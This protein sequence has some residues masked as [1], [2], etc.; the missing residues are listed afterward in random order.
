MMG[1]NNVS[2]FWMKVLVPARSQNALHAWV[3]LK[4]VAST[5]VITKL[6]EDST[7]SQ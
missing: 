2:N 1:V 7:T 3:M 4:S 6:V 5:Q